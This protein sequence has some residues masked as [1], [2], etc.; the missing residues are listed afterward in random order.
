LYAEKKT[1]EIDMTIELRHDSWA[2]GPKSVRIRIY[3]I[4][5][6]NGIMEREEGRWKKGKSRSLT[7]E[8]NK[9]AY[10]KFHSLSLSTLSHSQKVYTRRLMFAL[11][12]SNPS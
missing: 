3:I 7:E 12:H 8:N 10:N 6:R 4:K 1:E 5:L 9:Q 2:R 11:N